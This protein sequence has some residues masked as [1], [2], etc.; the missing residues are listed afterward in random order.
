LIETLAQ[1]RP[2][3]RKYEVCL[4]SIDRCVRRKIW[5]ITVA[6]MLGMHNFYKGEDKTPDDIV[7]TIEINE[8]QENGSPK[9]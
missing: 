3:A 8:A 1:L 5:A 4:L 9:D 6:Y 7:I 2:K